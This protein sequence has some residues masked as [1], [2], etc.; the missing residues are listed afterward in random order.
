MAEYLHELTKINPATG[1][2]LEQEINEQRNEA[3]KLQYYLNLMEALLEL[4]TQ[5]EFENGLKKLLQFRIQ[6][7]LNKTAKLL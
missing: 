4:R 7:N 6:I 5:I 3:Q 1:K 2:S